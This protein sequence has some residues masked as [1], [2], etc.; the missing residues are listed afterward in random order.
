MV[1]LR[2]G[3]EVLP[4][5]T[6]GKAL[7]LTVPRSDLHLLPHAHTGT[8]PSSGWGTRVQ[9]DGC[10]INDF[11]RKHSYEL[12]EVYLDSDSLPHDLASWIS[13]QLKSGNDL[14]ACFDYANAFGGDGDYGHVCVVDSCDEEMITLVDPWYL[15]PK[16]R[17]LT[18]ERLVTAMRQHAKTNRAGF[19]IITDD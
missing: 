5:E 6:I 14:L 7:G 9:D 16:Y 10:S 4:Q 11:F 8:Q 13:G 17:S 1:L 18:V 2:R 19:W 3:L 15:A 12:R